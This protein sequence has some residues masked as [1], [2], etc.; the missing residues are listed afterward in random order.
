[1]HVDFMTPKGLKIDGNK[2]KIEKS[3]K[4]KI[5]ERREKKD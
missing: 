5:R 1:M 4:K 2:K 3:M